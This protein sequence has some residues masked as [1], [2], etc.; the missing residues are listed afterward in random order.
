MEKAK[1]TPCP[2]FGKPRV[3][4]AAAPEAALPAGPGETWLSTTGCKPGCYRNA[5]P[6]RTA[7][8]PTWAGAQD[9]RRRSES[10][11]LSEERSPRF[12]LLQ[13][14]S[15]GAP[16]Q[17]ETSPPPRAGLQALAGKRQ[18]QGLPPTG[19]PHVISCKSLQ[20]LFQAYL[21]GSGALTEEERGAH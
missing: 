16:R 8:C 9:L 5:A 3:S 17:G 15:A 19:M 6:G 20:G 4:A 1:R 2:G 12:T 14:D 7:S 10:G 11:H 18:T 13:T 21:S